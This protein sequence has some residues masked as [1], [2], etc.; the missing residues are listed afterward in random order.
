[1]YKS[2]FR[3]IPPYY[4][5]GRRLQVFIF[6]S[7]V[8]ALAITHAAY[9][10]GT[11]LVTQDTNSIAHSF[12]GVTVDADPSIAYYNPA[13]MVLIQGNAFEG[14]LNLYDINSK[15]TG[16]DQLSEG[17]LSGTAASNGTPS[18]FLEETL[19][20][21]T[22][23]VNSL[24]HGIKIGLT[25]T[26]PNGGRIKYPD[27]FSGIYEGSEALLTEIQVSVPIAIPITDKL[28]IGAAPIL[29]WFQNYV[30]ITQNQ[31][32]L[33]SATPN[34]N[35]ALGRFR[36][37]SYAPGFDAGVMYQFSPDTRLGLNYHSKIVHDI[38]GTE[39][40]DIG[41]LR[42]IGNVVDNLGSLLGLGGVVALPPA[43]SSA[44]D[45]WVFPQSVSF[46][47][48]Q[49]LTRQIDVMASAQWTDW[50]QAGD[51]DIVDP[52]TSSFTG[53]GIYTPFHYRNA[54]TVGAGAD[55]LPIPRLRLMGGAGY[56]ET[57]VTTPYR[58]DLLPDNNRIMVSG[59]FSYQVRMNLKLE[60]A[61]AHYFIADPS[62][63]QTR[64]SLGPTGLSATQAGTL[65][66]EYS[67]SANVFS[68]GVV[69]K[70]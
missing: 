26:T 62:I 10:A 15:F 38:K 44:T 7:A 45:K 63:D 3:A 59:G 14:D 25:V 34:G 68:T 13:G 33:N 21:A 67:L 46:G 49:R 11:G 39:T 19:I 31:T 42:T 8:V 54:W 43:A 28:S 52:S 17:V 50:Q 66:G 2:V 48:F 40:V 61:Y 36:G 27:D 32:S 20:P 64:Q 69:L 37:S 1:M 16:Q 18:H 65:T 22:F 5:A 51:L 55:Y 9:G 47:L 53:G 35:G 56:D 60:A 57:P 41:E 4:V 23:A 29:D 24:P 70:F 30:S 12:G 58:N 6:G